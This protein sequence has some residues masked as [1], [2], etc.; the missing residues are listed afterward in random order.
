MASS[1]VF[2]WLCDALEQRTTLDRLEAR[3]TIRLALKVAGLDPK[4]LSGDQA[5]VL[6]QCVLAEEL[7]SRGIAD[8]ARV[9]ETLSSALSRQTFAAQ[10][11]TP[12]A[13]FGRLG[14]D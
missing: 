2:E 11:D 5:A 13:V 3:G 6:L 4:T 10:V 8:A 9:C 1:D 12:E 14:G 7:T